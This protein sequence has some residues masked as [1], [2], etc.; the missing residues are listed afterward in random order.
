[1]VERV[2]VMHNAKVLLDDAKEEVVKQLS[3]ASNV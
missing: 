1:M 3:G 2:I